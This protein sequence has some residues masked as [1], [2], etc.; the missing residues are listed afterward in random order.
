ML[1]NKSPVLHCEPLKGFGNNL[2]I[3]FITLNQDPAFHV[4]I[5][6]AESV[7]N[8]FIRGTVKRK[9]VVKYFLLF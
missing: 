8:C 9:A 1:Q 5:L 3:I 7:Y 2:K 6:R 4:E